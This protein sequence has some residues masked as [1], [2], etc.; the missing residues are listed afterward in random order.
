MIGFRHVNDIQVTT[1]VAGLAKGDFYEASN[2]PSFGFGGGY[3]FGVIGV[4]VM[5]A[6]A[7]LTASKGAP[8][9]SRWSG[10]DGARWSLPITGRRVLEMRAAALRQPH[11]QPACERGSVMNGH[12]AF[13]CILIVA[14]LGSYVPAPPLRVSVRSVPAKSRK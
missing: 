3:M 4:E 9:L 14:T 11:K 2:V 10:D 1:N 8:A 6:Y 13:S 12:R 5:A 7:G